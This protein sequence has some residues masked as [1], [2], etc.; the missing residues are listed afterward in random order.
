MISVHGNPLVSDEELG[1]DGKGGQNIYVREVGKKLTSL[2]CDVTWLTRSESKAE[3]G[4]VGLSERLRCR[5]IVAG[6]QTHIHRDHLYQYLD[7]FVA[8]IHPA[9]FDV[10]FTCYWLSAYVGM[11]LGLPHIHA[12][13]SLGYMKYR[14]ESMSSI[15]P[16]R[17]RIEKLVGELADVYVCQTHEEMELMQPRNP[18]YIPCGINEETF[19]KL[20]KAEA[21]E[22]MG[23]DSDRLNVL[24]VGR[25][26]KQKGYN[27]A[28]EALSCTTI[29]HTFRLI[30]D[31]KSVSSLKRHPSVQ[32]LG[33]KKP[34][35]VALFMAASDVLIMP[36]LYEPFG[37]VAIE[38]MAAGCCLIV[39][40]VG[41]LD[42]NVQDGVNGLKVPPGNSAAILAAFEKLWGDKELR[43][44]ISKTNRQHALKTYSWKSVAA[45]IKQNLEKILD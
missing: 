39:S 29:P 8:Q 33:S 1:S 16:T 35:E 32:L 37:L 21:Q 6:P 36:S 10:V 42:E 22:K 17:L 34:E 7:E 19:Q 31:C 25:F 44:R 9:A 45:E 5:F 27:Y 26:A 41:G 11:A 24:Y 38:A 18:V 15:G 4:V 13:M 20:D 23:F 3:S 14:Q 40:A 28:L 12:S 43:E 30:G 2:N